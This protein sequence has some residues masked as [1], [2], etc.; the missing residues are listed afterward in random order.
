MNERK[1][2]NVI[3]HN[4]LKIFIKGR[5]DVLKSFIRKSAVAFFSGAVLSLMTVLVSAG[6]ATGPQGYNDCNGYYYAVFNE[7]VTSP[8]FAWGTTTVTSQKVEIDFPAG[9]AGIQPYLYDAST[10]KVA[11]SYPMSYNGSATNYFSKSTKILESP[12]GTYYSQCITRAYHPSAVGA[13][14]YPYHQFS[15]PASP[16]QSIS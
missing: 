9:Y 8:E 6:I 7:V 4:V 16:Y 15:T 5:L 11:I 13:V 1:L 3:V 12:K 10:K 14:Y 2:K